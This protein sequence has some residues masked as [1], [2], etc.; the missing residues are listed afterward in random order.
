MSDFTTADYFGDPEIATDPYPYW[1][2]A[3]SQ[4]PVWREPRHQAA[5]VTGY[6][7]AISVYMD[8]R[9]WSACNTLS[10]IEPFPV[11][12]EGDDVSAEIEQHRDELVFSRNLGALDPPKHTAHRG[13]IAR[14][15]TPKRLA[16]NEDFMW[17]RADIEL[18][19]I[20]PKGHCEFISEFAHPFTASVI[21][22]LLGVPEEDRAWFRSETT[23]NQAYNRDRPIDEVV[24]E[25]FVYMHEKFA[26][27]VEDRRRHPRADVLASLAT[28]TF[29]DGTL[30]EVQEVVAIA[31]NLFGAGQETTVHLLNASL[32]RLAEDAGLQQSLR[33]NRDLIANFIEEELRFDSPA[34]GVFRLSR[35]PT[36]VAGVELGAGSVALIAV[37]AANRDP[38]KFKSPNEFQPDRPNAR[39]H[40]AFGHGIHTCVG[41]PL[42]RAETRVALNRILD[43]TSAIWISEE[44]H[45]PPGARRYQYRPSQL[46][47]PMTSLHLE[48][49]P[50]PC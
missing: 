34:K 50:A 24:D 4:C 16:E 11:P 27:Y 17:G 25:P 9:T 46:S 48:Y 39:Q 29:P 15:I 38:R 7:E 41:A 44:H 23:K 8:N 45:G 12:L 22:D 35:V 18:D 36:E 3:R 21:A 33:E 13:L 2:F 40:L 20:L 42:A 32:K 30:P 28:A 1:D 26:G 19:A 6:E 31:T 43:R 5:L 47:R 14:L 37:A 10:G 49:T